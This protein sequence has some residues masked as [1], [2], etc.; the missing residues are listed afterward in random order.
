M[1]WFAPKKAYSSG[2][3]TSQSYH[4][5]HFDCQWVKQEKAFLGTIATAH[6]QDPQSAV[7]LVFLE[8]EKRILRSLKEI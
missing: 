2:L 6:T 1:I 8:D 5:N 3:H 4:Q 7:S